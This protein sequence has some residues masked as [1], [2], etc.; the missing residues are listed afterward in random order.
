MRRAAAVKRRARKSKHR[1]QQS[2][3]AKI[4]ILE[5]PAPR[6]KSLNLL[7]ATL[8]KASAKA[9]TRD[10][11]VNRGGNWHALDKAHRTM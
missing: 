2:R 9:D 4:N 11:R 5:L 1:Q 3:K 6:A 10:K 7:Y 8:I